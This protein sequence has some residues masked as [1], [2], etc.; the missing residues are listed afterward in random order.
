MILV[1]SSSPSERTERA[2]T[3]KVIAQKTANPTAMMRMPAATPTS[4]PTTSAMAPPR[5][6]PTAEKIALNPTS[7]VRSSY[8]VVITGTSA[9]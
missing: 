3:K 9:W 5:M 8:W 2:A 6:V 7:R 4:L 1:A